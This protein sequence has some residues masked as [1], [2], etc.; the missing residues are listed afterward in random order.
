MLILIFK[1]FLSFFTFL[2]FYRIRKSRCS[3]CIHPKLS[4]VSFFI[5]NKYRQLYHEIRVSNDAHAKQK[6]TSFI[7]ICKKCCIYLFI[8]F[9][10]NKQINANA[11]TTQ[12]VSSPGLSFY[13]YAPAPLDPPNAR[14]KRQKAFPPEQL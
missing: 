5:I 2:A 14:F 7:L 6:G 13:N 4:L 11:F 9:D 10:V 3:Q 1:I 12:Y 8:K